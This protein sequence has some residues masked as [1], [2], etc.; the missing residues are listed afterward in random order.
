MESSRD[1]LV[2]L[3]AVCVMVAAVLIALAGTAA[4]NAWEDR[5][6]RRHRE[7]VRARLR[8]QELN[9]LGT[10]HYRMRGGK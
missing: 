8:T 4:W 2:V 7:D 10:R 3:V 6:N 9:R 5:Q 1:G